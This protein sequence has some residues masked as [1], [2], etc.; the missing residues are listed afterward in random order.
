[1]AEDTLRILCDIFKG[2]RKEGMY[3]YVS[4]ADGLDKV[5]QS[6]LDSFGTPILVTRLMLTKKKK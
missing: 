2:N 5:P 3:I 6:L 1:M 4:H